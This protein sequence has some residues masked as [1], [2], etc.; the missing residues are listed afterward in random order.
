M[1]PEIVHAPEPAP[2][3]PPRVPFWGWSDVGLFFGLAVPCLLATQLF[4][5]LLAKAFGVLTRD[6]AVVIGAQA[7]F[8]ACLFAVLAAILRFHYDAPFWRSLGWTPSRIPA[9]GA[10]AIGVFLAF[11]VTLLGTL[12]RVQADK[13]DIRKLLD[14]PHG[15]IAVTLFAVTLGPLAEE[16]AFRGFLQPLIVRS[17]GAVAGVIITGSLFGLLHLPEYGSSWG[18]AAMVALAGIGFGA[19]RYLSGSTRSSVLAHA[20]YNG[21]LFIAFFTAGRY[22]KT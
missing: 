19:V 2:L 20:G 11:A 18:A 13:S 21:V 5:H 8:Y 6:A 4:A 22:I 3:P 10:V 17:V 7:F 12:L 1:S 14:A 9:L 16:L 15:L